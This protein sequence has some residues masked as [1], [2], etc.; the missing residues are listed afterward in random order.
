MIEIRMQELS[1][2][3]RPLLLALSAMF[4]SVANGTYGKLTGAVSV[5]GNDA[6][7]HVLTEAANELGKAPQTIAAAD[8]PDTGTDAAEV[9][10]NGGT[11]VDVNPA[12]VFG[13]PG[14]VPAAP[15]ANESANAAATAS[16]TTHAPGLDLD[17][18]GLP[19]DARI[20]ASSKV[21][22][23]DG[24]W[25][26]KRGVDDAIVAAVTA[27][28]RIALGNAPVAASP[29]V[30]APVAQTAA[31]PT[32][33]VPAAPDVPNVPAPPATI[34][35]PV[36][37]APVATT[38]VP[39]VPAPT[40]SAASPSAPDG[41][42]ASSAASAAPL[43]FPTLCSRITS[44]I[45]AGTLTQVKLAEVLGRHGLTSLPTLAACMHKVP[46]VAR[47]LGYA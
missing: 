16:V 42:A 13:Q 31:I 27:E 41:N 7:K 32:P 3:D 10:A 29:V 12:A 24:R 45:A 38:N 1:A 39:N 25:R 8:T 23:A 40:L 44:D 19:W 2:S 17:A 6:A 30:P 22:N 9:F 35:A 47:D 4:Q 46:D 14:N 37:P 20:H 21:K 33:P 15:I 18:D 43:T 28:L 26:G 5:T 34:A 36:V 11:P